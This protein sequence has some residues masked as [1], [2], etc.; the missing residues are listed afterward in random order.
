MSLR[1]QLAARIVADGPLT[2]ADYMAA[3]LLDPVHGYYATRD[4]FGAAGDFITAPEISQMFGEV[5]G[6]CLA[7]VWLYQGAPDP[8]VLAEVGPGRGT[9]MADILRATRGVPGFHAAIRVHLVEASPVLR[10]VQATRVPQ[11]VWLDEVVQLPQMPLLLIANEFF[12]ALPIR[13]FQRSGD[14]WRERVVGLKG[15]ALT[16]GLTDAAPHAMLTHR[17]ADTAEGDIVEVCPALPAI[18]GTIGARIAAHGGAALV[19][20]YGDWTSLGDTFQAVRGHGVVD[21]LADPG[22]ADLTA[23]VDFATLAAAI[24][25]ARHT[26]LVPQGVFLERLGITARAQALAAGL[27]GDALAAHVAAH[28]RLTHPTQMGDHFKVIGVYPDGAPPPPGLTA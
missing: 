16:L 4:P 20:D 8:V 1:D 17:L 12:D 21:P 7:Q 28:R 3:C 11:A 5:I 6:L 26:R 19:I 27:T 9:L 18:A 24:A 13:A 10:G 25:P 22:A 23:H 14:G 15:D 2:L